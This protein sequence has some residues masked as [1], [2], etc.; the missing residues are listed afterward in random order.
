MPKKKYIIKTRVNLH[1][2]QHQLLSFECIH[3]HLQRKALILMI[4]CSVVAIMESF[5]K[6]HKLPKDLGSSISGCSSLSQP[7]RL[8]VDL[9]I[10]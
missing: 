9:W 1:H 10:V 8:I 5:G 7:M 3:F 4:R 2:R 6:I